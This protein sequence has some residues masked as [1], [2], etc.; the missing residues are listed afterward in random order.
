MD[1]QASGVGTL[2]MNSLVVKIALMSVVIIVVIDGNVKKRLE[3]L[4]VRLVVEP[5]VPLDRLAEGR[6]HMV[7]FLEGNAAQPRPEGIRDLEV[8]RVLVREHERGEK[9]PVNRQR[10]DLGPAPLQVRHRHHR[11][12]N[13]GGKP[14]GN[15]IPQTQIGVVGNFLHK[16]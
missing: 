4:G 3:E 1:R 2:L 10:V 6:L 16:S 12:P 13:P 5:E 7:E 11:T 14:V 8:L 15:V 9:V